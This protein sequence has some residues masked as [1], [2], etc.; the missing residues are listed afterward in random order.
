M[1]RF[2]GIFIGEQRPLLAQSCLPCLLKKQAWR[3]IFSVFP[4]DPKNADGEDL[5]KPDSVRCTKGAQFVPTL[6]PLERLQQG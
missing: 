3:R 4:A 6:S 2:A 5:R 1:F